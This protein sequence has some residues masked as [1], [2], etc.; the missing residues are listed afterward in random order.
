M[1]QS[2]QPV[3]NQTNEAAEKV[4]GE[5][6]KD[7]KIVGSHRVHSWY[8][9]A[10]IGIVLGMALGIVYV[11]NRSVTVQ[12]SD[13]AAA[14]RYTQTTAREK[15]KA[16]G[17]FKP[18][19][20]TIEPYFTADLTGVS[21]GTARV[22]KYTGATRPHIELSKV[23]SIP[24][25]GGNIIE[26]YNTILSAIRN[27]GLRENQVEVQFNYA[28]G[29]TKGN[30]LFLDRIDTA[31]AGAFPG[32]TNVIA[33]G[34]VPGQCLCAPSQARYGIMKIVKD[35][36]KTVKTYAKAGDDGKREYVKNP[37]NPTDEQYNGSDNNLNQATWFVLNTPEMK[38]GSCTTNADC[39][40]EVTGVLGGTFA[41][42]CELGVKDAVNEAEGAAG[43]LTGSALPYLMS[44]SPLSENADLVCNFVTAVNSAQ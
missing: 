8:A 3:Q 33:L 5:L 44:R 19:S 43:N 25:S 13:A 42:V 23:E 31:F 16:S 21:L 26:K 17:D 28:G 10:I 29:K 34:N 27:F 20:A 18:L 7:F 1:E 38:Y 41:N 24:L 14:K 36:E 32:I 35:G 37:A 9:W 15:Q 39:E 12:E 11:A 2:N 30:L 4:V 22:K 40:K 6:N